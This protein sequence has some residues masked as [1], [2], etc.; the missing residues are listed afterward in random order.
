MKQ[1]S[2][3]DILKKSNKLKNVELSGDEI[4]LLE[5]FKTVWLSRRIILY[6]I[7]LTSLI[8]LIV[9]FGVNVE[10]KSQVKLLIESPNDQGNLGRLS[11]LAGLA[12]IDLRG[13]GSEI[14]APE[15]FPEIVSSTPFQL[16]LLNSPIHF[17]SA[18]STTSSFY[19]FEELYKPTVISRVGQYF[20][21]I[22]AKIRGLLKSDVANKDNRNDSE[23]IWLS[24][25][26]QEL[27]ESFKNRI[28]V[29]FSP[30]T[31][32]FV[33]NAIMPEA[34]A[35]AELTD[36]IKQLLTERVSQYRV[37]KSTQNLEFIK[38]RYLIV[39]S[40]FNE[41]QNKLALYEDANL[42]LNSSRAKIQYT[43]LQNEYNLTYE[44]YKN[45]AVELEQ[46]RIA[47][48]ENT[49]VFSTIEPIIVPVERT[50]PKRTLIML[51]S[52]I[53]GAFL[54]IL[55]VVF[56]PSLIAVVSILVPIK[57]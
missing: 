15:L 10:F 45:L 5:I 35:S 42:N 9:S 34:L 48:S 51:T 8:G 3:T 20:L 38:D 57:K 22:P 55:V 27:L 6:I 21:K 40:D 12:G 52:V 44:L 23:I 32:T 2:E 4:D 41:I 1:D 47:V 49:P 30:E 56:K 28:N 46:A 43:R 33:I 37:K 26:E 11:G 18:D 31:Q 25:E 29:E 39:Q 17:Q 50:K 24:K 19:F 14:L 13:N 54:G 53:V 16:E 7:L 36:L